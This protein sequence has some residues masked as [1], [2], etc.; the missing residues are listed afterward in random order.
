MTRLIFVR[1]GFF[2]AYGLVRGYIV[3]DFAKGFKQSMEDHAKK[4]QVPT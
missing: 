2:I 3:K 4:C 1:N